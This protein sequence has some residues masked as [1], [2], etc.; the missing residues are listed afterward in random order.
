MHEINI[1]IGA[2]QIAY[3]EFL[4]RPCT[5]EHT[6]NKRAGARSGYAR[7][8]VALAPL[9]SGQGC[10][11]AIAPDVAGLPGDYVKAIAIGVANALKSGTLAGFPVTDLATTI[12]DA[13]YHESDSSVEAFE[14]AAQAATHE[15]LRGGGCVLIEPIMTLDIRA[16]AALTAAIIG[17]LKSRRGEIDAS[18]PVGDT[19][20]ITALV[21]LATL[22]GYTNTLGWLSHG[23]ASFKMEFRGY[24]VVP[25]ATDD[26]P[27]A[28]PAMAMR[29]G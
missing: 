10:E 22:F 3:R 24:A 7:V 27:P 19:V 8:K 2:P 25:S 6:Y 18:A 29:A 12:I 17:D 26:H 13:A 11:F 1:S 23:R 9:P 14:I 16:P 15:G 21:P 28:A 5:V 20:A 4:S